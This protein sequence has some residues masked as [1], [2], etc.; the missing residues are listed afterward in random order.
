MS[1]PKVVF[2][3]TEIAGYFLACC[4][5][6][7]KQGA[8]VHVVCWPVNPE[9]PFRFSVPE[10]VV[11]YDRQSYDTAR[12]LE[13]VKGLG[14]SVIVCSGWIDK[15]YLEVCKELN[16]KIPSVLTLD[17]HWKGGVKQLAATLIS[18]FYL[19][20]RFS[21]CWVPGTPQ[22]EYA[23]KLGF[24]KERVMQGFYSADL[25]LFN[26]HYTSTFPAKEKK[27]PKRFIYV[28]RYYDFKGV[29]ELWEAFAELDPA[30][31]ELWCFGT[32]D[33]APVQHPKIRHFG[34][35]QPDELGKYIADTGVF[36]LPSHKEPWGVVVHEFAAA[37]FPLVCSDRV[38]AASAFL[39][40][41]ENGYVY[42][43][44]DKDALKGVLKKIMAAGEAELA[45]M[46]KKSHE[47]AQAISPRLWANSLL[48]LIKR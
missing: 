27:F 22:S 12:L 7:V 20:R 46:G 14:P 48:G 17:N 15:G 40:E 42:K 47:R 41:G 5:E 28:G 44:E 45:A 24:K 29:G 23:L 8:E 13:L 6:L 33:V 10:G 19:H 9:A 30:E 18:P 2:L 25:D 21:W 11:L 34:F 31:W 1:S 39:K 16:R 4:R 37:G 26:S 43:G 36:V 3:Y 38:G 32:G 35:V